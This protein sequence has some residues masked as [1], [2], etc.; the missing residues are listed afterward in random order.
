MNVITM[1]EITNISKPELKRTLLTFFFSEVLYCAT[2]FDVAVDIP[3]SEN[4][5]IKKSAEDI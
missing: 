5:I 3:K 2:Y 1:Q 4:A